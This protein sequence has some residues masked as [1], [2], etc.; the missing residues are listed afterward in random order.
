MQVFNESVN[1]IHH[2]G[3]RNSLVVTS[4]HELF[5][6]VFNVK[7]NDNFY[8][9][10]QVGKYDECPIVKIP[11]TI[12]GNV[13]ERLFDLV[14]GRESKVIFN[15][16]ISN[17][18][19]LQE[20]E[21]IQEE[22]LDIFDKPAPVITDAAELSQEEI[23]ELIHGDSKTI[24]ES[25]E[26]ESPIKYGRYPVEIEKIATDLQ[27]T[28]DKLQ[29]NARKSIQEYTNKQ[30]KKLKSLNENDN[31][32]ADALLK[33]AK[34]D[35]I[36]EFVKITNEIKSEL[37]N[38]NVDSRKDITT[39]LDRKLATAINEFDEKIN[40]QFDQYTKIYN[41]TISKYIDVVLEDQYKPKLQ[42]F[43][44]TTKT[45]LVETFQELSEE[46]ASQV[47]EKVGVEDWNELNQIFSNNSQMLIQA[48]IEL[49]NK[50]QNVASQIVAEHV[51]DQKI[52]ES[53]TEIESHFSNNIQSINE[54]I[55]TLDDATRE[56]LLGIIAESRNL[57]LQEIATIKQNAAVEYVIE[58]K[59]KQEKLDITTLKSDLLKDLDSKISNAIVNL[60]KFTTYYGGGGGTVAQQFADGGTMNGNLTVVGAISANQ[61]LGLSIPSGEYLPLSGG[62]LTG[63]LTAYDVQFNT[64]LSLPSQ[65]GRLKWNDEDGTLDLG[66]KGGN[67][68]LQIGQEAVARV[69]NKTDANLLE[70][71]YKVVRI[72]TSADQPGG[73]Q[74]QRLA[75]V[76]AQANNDPNSVDTLG[77]VTE[78]ITKN[79]EGFV[80]T[81][82]LVRGINTTGTL[83]GETWVDG[84]VLYL[85]PFTAGK[86]TNIKPV[87]PNHAVVVGFV[88]YAHQ[89]EGKIFVKVDNG[90]EID[91]LHNVRITNL[92]G[93]D[94]LSYDALSG[95]WRNTQTLSISSLSADRIYTTHLDALSANITV[96]DIKQYELSGF[97][98]TGDVTINGTVSAGNLS[99]GDIYSNGNRVAT[100]VN[101]T[102]TTLTGNGV[103]SSF[104]L[105]GAD[106]LTNP[107]A[108][109]VA[110]DGALQ[111][112]SVDYTVNNG[113]ITFTDPLADGAKAVVVAPTNTLQL[114]EL[115]P[116]DGS[117]TS[118]KLAPSLT[119]TTPTINGG[120]LTDCTGYSSRNL[121]GIQRAMHLVDYTRQRESAA[122]N[123]PILILPLLANNIYRVKFYGQFIGLGGSQTAGVFTGPNCEFVRNYGSR[124]GLS[125]L[126]ITI[127]PNP[128]SSFGFLITTQNVNQYASWE[129]VMKPIVNGNV[130]VAWHCTLTGSTSGATTTITAGS[131]IEA[132]IIG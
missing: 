130:S 63:P 8:V 129:L 124:T 44:D 92:S 88:V 87:A 98:V 29:E 128:F 116:S 28:V 117:V 114:G 9:V 58:S 78:N 39:T 6:G 83:Q 57:L 122:T 105:S 14:V 111:E 112:P 109:I 16:S 127:N 47:N 4:K 65:V 110:I 42:S 81:S 126:S 34:A 68:T 50:I 22:S 99:A 20:A 85:S 33:S 121:A 90:Y 10:E 41:D 2:E 3:T 69:V 19:M 32:S 43:I 104:T 46:V 64:S 119:L 97:N 13:E 15:E 96:I 35:L 74:G 118:G 89:N 91:E 123:D 75:V 49:N 51:I 113:I 55:D 106:N 5:F 40:R 95:V 115:I 11:V 72:R 38:S 37:T 52:S 17:F 24:K 25:F 53:V 82:G 80:T 125:P 102:R 23:D 27:E 70:S 79:Q 120:V 131:Y 94:V 26:V 84:D 1:T 107:S 60:K 100:V 21:N 7:V 103:L 54:K 73:A 66:L 61:Y 45:E 101:P 86:L 67:V 31:G 71:E 36:E 76:L 62:M 18:D 77:L 59:T 93:G 56:H 48:N 30:L 108:L 132:E 12:D